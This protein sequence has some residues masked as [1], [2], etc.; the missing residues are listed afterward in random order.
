MTLAIATSQIGHGAWT[1]S[2]ISRVK[3][4][5][6]DICSATDWTPWNMIEMPTT[7]ATRTVANADSDAA[8]P[9]ADPGAPADGLADLGEHVEEHEAQEE[10]LDDACAARTPRRSCAARRGRGGA[11]PRGRC[12][13]RRT[14]CASRRG[15]RG[16]ARRRCVAV[17]GHQSRSSLPVRLM[18]TVSRVGSATERSSTAKPGV[19]GGRDGARE[20]PVA[21]ADVQLEPVVGRC[22]SSSPRRSPPSRRGGEAVLVAARLD[23]HDGVDADAALEPLGRVEGEDPAVV[24]DRDAA[25]ELVGLLHVVR[26]EQDRLA[27]VVAARGGCP[28]ARGGS[29][30][31]APPSARP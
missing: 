12:G 25:A 26:G 5:S 13:S 18:N 11:A 24:H 2:S 1:R 27:L 4:N 31:R 9:A 28:T 22:A 16:V 14:P 10:R 6:W 30:G 3:P 29:G 15:P 19:L 17:V 20:Q 8:A 21:A 7:P 23:R